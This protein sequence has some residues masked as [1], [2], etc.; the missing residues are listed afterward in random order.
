MDDLD[1]S[2][3]ESAAPARKG[4][5][6]LKWLFR[7]VLGM[8]LAFGAGAGW[9]WWEARTAREQVVELQR[10]IELE[11]LGGTLTAALVQA[12]VGR[13]ED[14]RQLTSD[15]FT[16]LQK[17]AQGTSELA[18]ALAEILSE[19]DRII[20]V[21]SRGDANGITLLT[22]VHRRYREATGL[23]LEAAPAP[24]P[25]IEETPVPEETPATDSAGDKAAEP[26]TGF[27][28]GP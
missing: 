9:Q 1:L 16:E 25:V 3:L 17:Q 6:T 10:S 15:F 26:Q 18:P 8:A 12:G 19:R 4:P 2:D 7:L 5:S 21:L 27:S 22:N 11:R 20:T 23:S 13:Y 14:A 28:T 24:S